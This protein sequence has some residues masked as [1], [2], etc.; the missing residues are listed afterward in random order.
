M[1]KAVPLPILKA[2]NPVR[3]LPAGAKDRPFGLTKG[4]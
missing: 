3:R 1:R 2:G 4:I